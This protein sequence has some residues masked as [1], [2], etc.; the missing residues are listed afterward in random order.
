MENNKTPLVS[1]CCLSYNHESFIRQCLEGFLMQKTDFPFEVL[2]HDDASTDKTADI[3][4]EYESENPDIIK[5]LY[6]TENQWSKGR[7]GSK[8]FNFP[9]AKG[10]Y[11]ALCEGDDYWTDP[12][13]LQKQVD[14]L[15]ANQEYGLVHTDIEYVDT[16]S[17]AIEP[18]ADLHKGI[19]GRVFNGYIWDY[20]LNNNG[21]ILT[22]SCLFRN[23][24]LSLDLA[25]RWFISDGWLFMELSRKSQV[26]FIPEKTSCYRLNPNGLMIS[27]SEYITGRYYHA[28]LDQIYLFY[29]DK[30]QILKYYFNPKT[31]NE[32]AVCL[33]RLIIMTKF[34]KQI[35]LRKFIFII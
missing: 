22:C 33:T 26:F 9:R 18:T 28:L 20:Y 4:R 34:G 14:F 30:N 32:I 29:K 21:F 6:E 8:E 5:P 2:I 3:I 12:Y 24:L 35:E 27:N 15:E 13:K 17:K 31:E 25:N 10:K 19:K 1:I 23:S 16:S 7:G 11:I